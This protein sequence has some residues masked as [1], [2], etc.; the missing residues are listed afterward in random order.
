MK[1]GKLYYCFYELLTR[2]R[3]FSHF[4][5]M[6][7]TSGLTKTCGSLWSPLVSFSY[8]LFFFLSV[9]H[10]IISWEGL[11]KN[12]VFKIIIIIN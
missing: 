1:K 6:E 7:K 2:A 9:S 11:Q 4:M 10:L 3:I 5:C 12:I 8:L